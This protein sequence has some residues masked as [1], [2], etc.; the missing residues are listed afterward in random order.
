MSR[1]NE[2]CCYKCGTTEGISLKKWQRGIPTYICRPCRRAD[3]Q[4]YV[5]KGI[6]PKQ[7]QN[8]DMDK[9]YEMAKENRARISARFRRGAT[10]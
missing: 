1:I 7:I 10:A 3:Y 6:E 8:I 2:P 4:R 9:W 5:D